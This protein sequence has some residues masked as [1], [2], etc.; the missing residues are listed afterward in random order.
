M[1]RP[2]LTS[3]LFVTIALLP[4]LAETARAQQTAPQGPPTAQTSVPVPRTQAAAPVAGV[5]NF[6]RVDATFACGGALS[7]DAVSSLAQAG[8]KSIVNIRTAG[9]PDANIEA[10]AQAAK[11]AGLTYIHLPFASASP[12]ATKVDEFLKA[13]ADPGNQPMLLHCAGGVRAS[14][15]WAIKRVMI[16]GWT[17]D[18][19]LAELPDLSK[20]ISPGL[21]AFML[22]YL[23][24]HGR[25]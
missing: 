1:H 8:F 2:T 16:D 19:A 12:D 15:F 13:V 17:V 18:K 10:H 9:E 24:Q 7:A 5:R 11:A 23:K 20:N 14:M 3:F 21:R 22:D 6:T 25:L 4:G